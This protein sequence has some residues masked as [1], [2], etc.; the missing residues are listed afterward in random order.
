MEWIWFFFTLTLRIPSG[1]GW[2]DPDDTPS[3][4]W[5][6]ISDAIGEAID[7]LLSALSAPFII[8]GDALDAIGEGIEQLGLSIWSFFEQPLVDIWNEIVALPSVIMTNLNDM[9]SFLFVPGE[10]YFENKFNAIKTNFTAKIGVDADDLEGLQDATG[11]N[12]DSISAFRG[13]VY[14][15]SVKFVDFSFLDGILPAVHNLARGFV[16]PL[17]LLY[18]MNQVYFLIRG[19]NLIGKGKGED[20]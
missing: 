19:V 12:L 20:E 6:S 7:G 1:P 15:Q 3:W 9:L 2:T 18:N 5:D 16:Y 8:I 10:Q 4:F 17:L 13:T 14:G 11:A